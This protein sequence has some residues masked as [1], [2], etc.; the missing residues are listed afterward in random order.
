MR[1]NFLIF[2]IAAALLWAGPSPL[3]A[4]ELACPDAFAKRWEGG[5]NCVINRAKAGDVKAQLEILRHLDKRAPRSWPYSRHSNAD[6]YA[7]EIFEY[8]D[9]G[10]GRRDQEFIHIKMNFM[11]RLESKFKRWKESIDQE[12]ANI[13][14]GVGSNRPVTMMAIVDGRTTEIEYSRLQ[15]HR[16]DIYR[17]EAR[18]LQFESMGGRTAIIGLKQMQYE[19]GDLSTAI[20]IISHL[21]GTLKKSPGNLAR[22]IALLEDATKLNDGN[23]EIVLGVMYEDGAWVDRDVTRAMAYCKK[24]WGKGAGLSGFHIARQMLPGGSLPTDQSAAYTLMVEAHSKLNLAGNQK[25]KPVELRR[26]QQSSRL[27]GTLLGPLALDHAAKLARKSQFNDAFK[28][29]LRAAHLGLQ[30]G[31]LAVAYMYRTGKGVPKKIERFERQF[32]ER[33]S[34]CGIDSYTNG[35]EYSSALC[36]QAKQEIKNI[37]KRIRQRKR[38]EQQKTDEALAMVGLALLALVGGAGGEHNSAYEPPDIDQNAGIQMAAE[39]MWLGKW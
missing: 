4:R 8:L 19:A 9:A 39:L 18:I 25:P 31:N 17:Y 10:V 35:F 14:N 2:C 11:E 37:G 13:A 30:R 20:D 3:T 33:A 29:Y 22:L 24:G 12:S 21:L 38:V 32:F 7:A 23:A 27:I 15:M 1:L 36:A 16:F 34:K 5:E 6:A 28:H 26:R